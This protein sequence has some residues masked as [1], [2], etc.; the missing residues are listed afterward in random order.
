MQIVDMNFR[1]YRQ[2]VLSL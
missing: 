1:G 2:V